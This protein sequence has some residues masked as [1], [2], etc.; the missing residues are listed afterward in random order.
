MS[1]LK[2]YYLPILDT[3]MPPINIQIDKRFLSL[4]VAAVV[5]KLPETSA[6]VVPRVSFVKLISVI[7]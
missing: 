7:F 5:V 3:T 6:T 4:G 1:N 2:L